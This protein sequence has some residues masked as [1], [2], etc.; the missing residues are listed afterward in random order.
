MKILLLLL[1]F[2]HLVVVIVVQVVKWCADRSDLI[3]LVFDAH[4]LDMGEEFREV[5]NAIAHHG[6]R[7]SASPPLCTVVVVVRFS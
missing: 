1:F 6:D 7:V 2:V 5:I 3:L 4:K